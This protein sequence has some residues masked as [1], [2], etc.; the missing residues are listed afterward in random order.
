MPSKATTHRSSLQEAQE[1]SN[2]AQE[3]PNCGQ[4]QE[5]PE[6]PFTVHRGIE[7]EKPDGSRAFLWDS[8]LRLAQECARC[9]PR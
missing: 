7:W 4:A 2:A 6:P 5:H 8:N 1:G 3:E 9:K